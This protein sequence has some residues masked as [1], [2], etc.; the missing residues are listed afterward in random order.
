MLAFLPFALVES[1]AG[2]VRAKRAKSR[3]VEDLLQSFVSPP[4]SS[5]V[6]DGARRS[7]HR[8]KA[9]SGGEL[10]GGSEATEIACLSQELSGQDYPHPRKR[11]DDVSFWVGRYQ[12]FQASFESGETFFTPQYL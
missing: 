11:S 5:L 1:L 12:L 2:F 10:V 3:A 7:E 6:G 9:G 8:S 4:C